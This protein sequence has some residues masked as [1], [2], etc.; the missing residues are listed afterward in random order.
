[1]RLDHLLSMENRA[2][3]QGSDREPKRR[4]EERE[5]EG[6]RKSLLFNFQGADQ[7]REQKEPGKTGV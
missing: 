1:M 5:V 6:A 2:K 7:K 4:N 3:A